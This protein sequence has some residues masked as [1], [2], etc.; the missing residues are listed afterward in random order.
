M[1]LLNKLFTSASDGIILSET[2]VCHYN[3]VFMSKY[4]Q[5]SSEGGNREMSDYIVKPTKHIQ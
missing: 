5:G 4:F 1:E 2:Q 3:M